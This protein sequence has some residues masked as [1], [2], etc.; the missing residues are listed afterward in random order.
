MSDKFFNSLQSSLE[1]ERKTSKNKESS[2]DLF[3]EADSLFK[4]KQTPAQKKD[5]IIR[6]TFTIA[7]K[8]Y[9]LIDK[10]KNKLLE[11]KL[12]ATKSEILRMALVSLDKSPNSN[13][14]SYYESIEKVRLGR[15]K[16]KK[17]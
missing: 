11:N 7:E 16:H 13:L 10:C 4:K 14:I 9:L 15:P 12:S 1:Q 2:V 6:D 5:K 8:E 17:L 3:K